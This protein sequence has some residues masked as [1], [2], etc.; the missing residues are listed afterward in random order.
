M[1]CASF[2]YPLWV[3]NQRG[4]T[5]ILSILDTTFRNDAGLK[6]N[7][8]ILS[9]SKQLDAVCT[10]IKIRHPCIVYCDSICI[11]IQTSE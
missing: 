3:L 2:I 5:E 6:C 8:P 4:E 11:F 10:F 9:F 1:L 7:S